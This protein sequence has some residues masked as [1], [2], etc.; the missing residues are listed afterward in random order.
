MPK[1]YLECGKIVTTHGVRGEVKVQPWCDGP[2]FLKE[3]KTFYFDAKGARPVRA[4]SVKAVGA[5]GVLKFEG[6]DTVEQAAALRNQV[7]YIRRSEAKLAE[8]DYFI[9]DLVGLQVVDAADPAL[10]YGELVDVSQTGAND[11][12]HIATEGGEVLI[13]AIRQVVQRVDLDEGRMYITPL[14]GL[15]DDVD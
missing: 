6:V 2:A 7:L 9:Q 5:M 1:E 12:Y 13:P 14:K 3:F 4:Q 10:C 8:G 11:V 15:F